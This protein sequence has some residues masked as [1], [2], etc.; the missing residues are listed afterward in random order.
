MKFKERNIYWK[1]ILSL[2]HYYVSVTLFSFLKYHLLPLYNEL[3]YVC[4]QFLGPI[5]LYKN[6]WIVAHQAPL[7]MGFLRQEKWSGLPYP[8]LGVSF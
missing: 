8:P 2:D 5:Q 3:M 7:S 6:P 4:T 1:V